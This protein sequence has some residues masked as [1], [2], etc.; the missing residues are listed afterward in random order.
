MISR[1]EFTRHR[2]SL[3]AITLLAERVKRP[4]LLA[5]INREFSF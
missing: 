4:V 2:Q 5:V 1:F 3:M